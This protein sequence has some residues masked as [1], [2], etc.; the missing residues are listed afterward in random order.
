MNVPLK[1]LKHQLRDKPFAQARTIVANNTYF[2]DGPWTRPYTYF[3]VDH[4][5]IPPELII[6]IYEAIGG[7]KRR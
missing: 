1:T 5:P 2:K 7:I 4:N 6:L 3:R